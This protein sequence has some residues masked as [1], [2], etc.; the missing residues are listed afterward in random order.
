M[1]IKVRIVLAGFVI[2]AIGV[3]KWTWVRFVAP[4]PISHAIILAPADATAPSTPNNVPTIPVSDPAPAPTPGGSAY[5]SD[6]ARG[7]ASPDVAAR[8][9]AVRKLQTLGGTDPN[10]LGKG[11]PQWGQ[12]MLAAGYY[13]DARKLAELAALRRAL[14]P[15]VFES[16]ERYIVIACIA[17]SNAETSK[18]PKAADW[19]DALVHA[20]MY[21]NA[22]SLTGTAEAA[23][24]LAEI[25]TQTKDT[26]TAQTFLSQ[27]ASAQPS[28]ILKAIQC[29]HSRFEFAVQYLK[30]RVGPHGASYPSLIS[31]GDY[32]LIDDQPDQA[33]ECFEG[34]CRVAGSKAKQVRDAIEGVARSIRAK[35]GNV[36][37][38]NAL[39]LELRKNPESAGAALFNTTPDSPHASDLQSAALA[40][41]TADLSK[42][43][44]SPALPH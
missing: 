13:D 9:D 8:E 38:A 33:R 21:Y 25:L 12:P 41:K 42:L 40:L 26:A 22:A 34:A 43:D 4:P 19:A 10:S 44:S 16:A 14:D 5:W 37:R 2:F 36:A 27:Q 32:Y 3:A 24:M 18:D 28:D 30:G 23:N 6:I 7:L 11:I 20:R 35:D 1:D 39:I 29:D 15:A 31:Q 17:Q